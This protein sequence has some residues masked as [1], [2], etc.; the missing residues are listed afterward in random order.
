MFGVKILGP[1]GHYAK[2]DAF[3][4]SEGVVWVRYASAHE[5]IQIKSTCMKKIS[6]SPPHLCSLKNSTSHLLACQVNLIY[7]SSKSG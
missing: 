6:S 5:R 1:V 7:S 3:T 4:L 2:V